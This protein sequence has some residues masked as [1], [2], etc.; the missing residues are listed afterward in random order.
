VVLIQVRPLASMLGLHP[1][2]GDDWARVVV[3]VAVALV[4]LVLSRQRLFSRG[5]R[6]RLPRRGRYLPRPFRVA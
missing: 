3:G 4:P 1:L 5:P 6:G 2:H